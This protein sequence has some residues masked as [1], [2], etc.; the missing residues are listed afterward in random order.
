MNCYLVEGAVNISYYM[1][2]NKVE[3]LTNL[4][5]A[6]DEE[7][8]EFKFRQHYENKTQEYCTYYSVEWCDVKGTIVQG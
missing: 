7:D 1:A 6:L 3:K 5:M 8:A 4:V 2:G